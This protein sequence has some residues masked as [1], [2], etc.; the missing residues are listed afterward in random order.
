MNTSP[1]SC[2]ACG[3]PWLPFKA[4]IL[5]EGPTCQITVNHKLVRSTKHVKELLGKADLA[6]SVPSQ[7]GRKRRPLTSHCGYM[8][9]SARLSCYFLRSP[10]PLRKAARAHSSQAKHFG[11]VCDV[12]FH[13]KILRWMLFKLRLRSFS[14]L[15][16]SLLSF[17]PSFLCAYILWGFHVFSISPPNL[18]L[19]LNQNAIN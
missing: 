12:S 15:A 1:P 8:T 17:S 2:L 13:M 14:V 10:C 7:T 9:G 19:R 16:W 3:T 11:H 4:G 6:I 5:F 18:K